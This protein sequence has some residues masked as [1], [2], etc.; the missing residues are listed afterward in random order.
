VGL[1]GFSGAQ[2]W[3][4]DPA[5]GYLRAWPTEE[6]AER[7][8]WI[9]GLQARARRDGNRFVPAIFTG[10]SGATVVESA[11]RCWEAGTWQPGEAD[12]HA[13]PSPIRLA[14][15]CQALA[16][17]HLAWSGETTGLLSPIPAVLRRR[18]AL[19]AVVEWRQPVRRLPDDPL[20]PVAPIVGRAM[21][22]LGR[23]LP[24][25]PVWLD[26]CAGLSLPLQPC[27]G[28]PWHDHV[29]FTG[30]EVTGWI[31][32]GAARLDH[33]ASDLARLLGSLVGDDAEGWRQGLAAYTERCRL[34]AEECDL[35]RMLDRSATVL[36]IGRWLARLDANESGH[37]RRRLAV[38]LSDLVRRVESWHVEE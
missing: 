32:F 9:H 31:D 6:T 30:D 17:L 11:G 14:R 23:W 12:Y 16:R 4:L 27:H 1:P 21:R 3:R 28:D 7:L 24:E 15:A 29:L 22:L 36:A 25:V 33:P 2:I 19:H 5:G 20:D 35:A 10:R 8:A 34:S 37:D 26:R 13:R 38:R 18:Q